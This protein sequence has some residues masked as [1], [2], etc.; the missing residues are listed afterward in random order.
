MNPRLRVGEAP[1]KYH[2]G[3]A[4]G[5]TLGWGTAL[6]GQFDWGGRLLKVTEAPKGPPQAGRKSA[7]ERKGRRGP[8]CE[9]CKP[10]R[11]ESRA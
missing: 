3:A 6:G 4:G 9:A 11:G 5:L 1:V 2:P 10:S 7:G 8:D